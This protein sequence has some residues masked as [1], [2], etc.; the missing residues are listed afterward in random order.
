MRI[1]SNKYIATPP[2]KTI[3]EMFYMVAVETFSNKSGLDLKQSLEFFAELK[4][5]KPITEDIAKMLEKGGFGSSKFWLNLQKIYDDKIE[6]I[7]V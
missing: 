4:E 3:E 1:R 5:G 2:Y 7:N 6:I